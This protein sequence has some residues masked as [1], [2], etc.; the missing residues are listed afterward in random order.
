MML[1]EDPKNSGKAAYPRKVDSFSSL[2]SSSP[3]RAHDFQK[4]RKI[5]DISTPMHKGPGTVSL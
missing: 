1:T 3:D 2:A 5:L 4:T